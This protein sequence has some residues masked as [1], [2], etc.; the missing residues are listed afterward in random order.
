MAGLSTMPEAAVANTTQE[1]VINYQKQTI[2]PSYAKAIEPVRDRIVTVTK[3]R[4]KRDT[5]IKIVPR[6]IYIVLSIEDIPEALS[7]ITLSKSEVAHGED[8]NHGLVQ[9]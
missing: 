3:Y 5:V 1:A 2:E 6:N 4:T 8:T 9:F 7:E